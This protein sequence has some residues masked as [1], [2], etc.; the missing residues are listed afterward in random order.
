MNRK[1]SQNENENNHVYDLGWHP[2]EVKIGPDYELYQKGIMFRVLNRIFLF[3]ETSLAYFPK[4]F[5]WGTIVKGKQYIKKIRSG[6]VVSNHVYPLDLM[7]ILSAFYPKSLYVTVLQS[8]L[9]LGLL[10][11]LIRIS[12]G[13]PIPEKGTDFVRFYEETPEIIK[14][15]HSILFYPEAALIPYC[16]HIRPLHRG[17]FHFA[18]QSTKWVIPTVITF[19]KPKGFYR[20]VRKNKPCIHYTVLKP[21]YIKDLGN[22]KSSVEKAWKDVEKIM[23]DYF[24]KNSDYYYDK[25]GKR[26]STPMP[27]NRFLK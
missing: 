16:D 7:I 9:G 17:A 13:V 3:L 11:K 25:N 24:V 23:S 14:N 18:Y 27:Y 5:F 6:V 10:S 8:N 12:G 19:H 21:Y 1:N 26:N 22:P 15:G 4:R 20:L 2:N